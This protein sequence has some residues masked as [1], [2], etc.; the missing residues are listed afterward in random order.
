[1][2]CYLCDSETRLYLHKNGYDLYECVSCGLIRT[3]LL[4]NYQSFVQDHY[5]KGYFTGDPNKSAYADYGKDKTYIT[6]NLSKF[7]G[8]IKQRKPTGKF[9]DVGCAY[10]YAVELGLKEGFDAYGF[11]ASSYAADEARTLV[12]TKRIQKG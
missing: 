8:F 7:L 3:N 10:G 4:G 11:D 9:L 1:M 2:N 12:G 5:S 6:M